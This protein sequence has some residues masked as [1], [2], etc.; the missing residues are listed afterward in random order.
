[1]NKSIVRLDERIIEKFESTNGILLIKG[2]VS[3][4]SDNDLNIICNN[5]TCSNDN[6]LAL[7]KPK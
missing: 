6:C 3:M 5:K 1:M 4:E 2:G 7:C